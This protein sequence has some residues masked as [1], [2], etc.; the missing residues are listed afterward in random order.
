MGL[1]EA[2]APIDRANH[3]AV[4]RETWGH[5]APIKN[6]TYRGR[7]VYVCGC[8][9]SGDL[10]PTPIVCEFSGLESSPWLYSAVNEW[11]QDLPKHAE[12]T[13]YE[14]KGTVRNYKFAGKTRVL[15]KV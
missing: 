5:L 10:N 2:F 14:F 4:L 7:I 6:R 1:A 11:L 3:E 8:W 15:L 9:D 13:I 12:G